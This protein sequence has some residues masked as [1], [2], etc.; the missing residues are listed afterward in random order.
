MRKESNVL[1]WLWSLL[2]G[3]RTA[4]ECCCAAVCLTTSDIGTFNIDIESDCPTM[5][6]DT[7]ELEATGDEWAMGTPV[8]C[9]VQAVMSCV[10][11]EYSLEL[12]IPMCT[13]VNLTGSKISA[14][15]D[16]VVIYFPPVS[17]TGNVNCC[18]PG[19][20]SVE[21]TVSEP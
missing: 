17:F 3:A 6:C 1:N 13:V 7:G 21:A 10:D 20:F 18:S 11:G 19:T 16:P 12:T 4:L 2:F 5:D 9:S 14:P 15:G 8:G